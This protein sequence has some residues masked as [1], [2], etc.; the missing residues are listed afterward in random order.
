M[1]VVISHRGKPSQ[2]IVTCLY[3][4]V[5]RFAGGQAQG[6]DITAIVIKVGDDHQTASAI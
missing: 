1:E 6:D 4:E 2:E 3:E 5:L